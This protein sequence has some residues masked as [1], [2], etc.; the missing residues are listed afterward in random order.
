MARYQVRPVL[1]LV[2]AVAAVSFMTACGHGIETSGI[3]S[4]SRCVDSTGPNSSMDELADAALHTKFVRTPGSDEVLSPAEVG[5]RLQHM[6]NANGA[7]PSD[8]QLLDQTRNELYPNVPDGA[9]AAFA[10]AVCELPMGWGLKDQIDPAEFDV[11]RATPHLIRS[12]GRSKCQA[13]STTPAADRPT[14]LKS[15]SDNVAEI[16][17]D[18]E[19][20][21][22][23]SLA[24]MEQGKAAANSL[25]GEIAADFDRRLSQLRAT[26]AADL[27]RVA[28][29]QLQVTEATLSKMCPN[30]P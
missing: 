14:Q 6:I 5:G 16:E 10:A 25:G 1:M 7:P 15:M 28:R 24:A 8:A 29:M 2:S 13:W 9:D 17:R 22:A 30:L 20:N 4:G 18:P 23:A 11:V 3:V 21:K 27:A 12:F 26:P 19:A